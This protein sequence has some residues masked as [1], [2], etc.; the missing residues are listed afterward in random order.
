MAPVFATQRSAAEAAE[1]VRQVTRDLRNGGAWECNVA[2]HHCVI[3]GLAEAVEALAVPLPLFA[4]V[5]RT[6][7]GS[8]D[9]RVCAQFTVAARHVREA[10]ALAGSTASVVDQDMLWL[11]RSGSA[12]GTCLNADLPV[13]CDAQLAAAAI[14][15]FDRELA[16]EAVGSRRS[17]D[18]G[19]TAAAES[20]GVICA[21]LG[22]AF[23]LEVPLVKDAYAQAGI[24]QAEPVA[25]RRLLGTAQALREARTAVDC[26]VAG[27]GGQLAASVGGRP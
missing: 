17:P 1:A 19:I 20:L 21:E 3:T 24:G 2:T 16:A 10:A 22:E 7:D 23:G 11:R 13:L 27:I 8:V 14:K 12:H 6:R 25:R 26:A 15:V 9:R 4:T 5:L 18:E